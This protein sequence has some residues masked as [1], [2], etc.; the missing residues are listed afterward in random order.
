M[1]RA[2]NSNLLDIL[3]NN[4]SIENFKWIAFLFEYMRYI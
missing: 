4:Q 2:G 1:K 3:D